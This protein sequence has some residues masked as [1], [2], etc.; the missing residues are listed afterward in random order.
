MVGDRKAIAGRTLAYGRACYGWAMKRERLPGNPF[1]NLPTDDYRVASRDRVLTGE[2]LSAIWRA[3]GDVGEPFGSIVRLLILTA[4]RESEVG[5][6]AWAEL[7]DDLAMWMIPAAR[8]KNGNDHLVP[9]APAARELLTALS[10]DHALV[11]PGNAGTGFQGWSK[12]KARLDE[13]SGVTGWRLHDLRRTAAT[14][15]QRLGVRLEVTEAV[16]N[17]VAGTRAGIVGVYQRHNWM[18]EKRTALVGSPA[19][20]NVIPLRGSA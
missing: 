16:L 19:A 9:L 11:F 18:D 5:G 20:D 15:L 13:R 4:Q 1:A 6:V 12:A 7:S 10:R 3:T 14:G 8:A 2:E 17:H